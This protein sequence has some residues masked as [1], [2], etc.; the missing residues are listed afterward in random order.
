MLKGIHSRVRYIGRKRKLKECKRNN[1]RVQK[2]IPTGYRRCDE[3]R[4]QR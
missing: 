1:Q 3:I 2:G 4:T